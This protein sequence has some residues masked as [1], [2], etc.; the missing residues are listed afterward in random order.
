MA[1]ACCLD[2]TLWGLYSSLSRKENKAWMC[3]ARG[4][5]W[6]CRCD[7]QWGKQV[8]PAKERS[9]L[10]W[11]TDRPSHMWLSWEVTG[12][13][14]SW[15]LSWGV[16][17]SD[18]EKC[19]NLLYQKA[20][21]QVTVYPA[22]VQ[23]A[24]GKFYSSICLTQHICVF[25]LQ[26]Q[27]CLPFCCLTQTSFNTESLRDRPVIKALK[28]WKTRMFVYNMGCINVCTECI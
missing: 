23:W 21:L 9:C 13:R 26:D 1:I 7:G 25:P 2:Q 19:W 28:C 10:C 16:L 3:T 11:R 17:C 18:L 14:P 15:V 22:E 12:N 4:C 24:E 5:P 20:M 8:P 6:R 27:P